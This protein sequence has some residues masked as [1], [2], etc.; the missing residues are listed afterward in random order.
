MKRGWVSLFASLIL[1][2]TVA[3]CTGN[4]NDNGSSDS[5]SKDDSL[6]ASNGKFT[7]EVTMTTARGVG[8]DVVFKNGDT[9]ENN[10]HTRW[11]KDTL[12]IDIKYLWTVADQNGA[13]DTK[14][15]LS[16]SANEPFPD[17]L[18]LRSDLVA[19]D[20]IDSGKFADG[21]ALFDKYA[22]DAWKAAMNEAPSAWYPYMR[23][24]KRI[25]IPILERAYNADT[26]LWIR[27]D[28]LKKL[29][30]KAPTTI[31]ELDAVMDAF[32]NQD[33]DGND[34]K[35]T[36]G[37]AVGF[38]D[39]FNGWGSTVDW[40]LGAY[41]ALP[42][43]WNEDKDGKLVYGSVQPEAKLG[44]TKLHD[45]MAKGYITKEAGIMDE[46]KPTESFVAGKTG[47]VAGPYWMV[48]WPIGAVKDNVPGA[49]IKAYPI[50]AGPNGTVMRHGTPG[51]N[52]VV[53]INKDMKHPEIFFA[54]Q[55]YLFDHYA[56]PAKGDPMEFGMHQGYDY[57]L[58]DNKPVY[59]ADIPGG[60]IEVEKY[61]LTFDGAIIPSLNMKTLA[62][63]G[64][65][66]APE[67][68]FEVKNS[69]GYAPEMLAAAGVV[70]QQ[71][72]ASHPDK[73]IGA[74]TPTMKA[75]GEFLNKLVLETYNKMIYG[76]IPI[77]H[78]EDFVTQWKQSGGDQMTAEAN[79]WYA[80][81]QGK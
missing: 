56:N 40:V 50:P 35:D 64:A 21:G 13:L 44:L 65:G 26:V 14:L 48:A 19:Q 39:R 6:P 12:G 76:D 34:K 60:A 3:G 59:G 79:D 57:D 28:W 18:P 15:R 33:P 52:G 25:G 24:G 11:A 51:N 20:L 62:A 45:W 63:L 67:S 7:P 78:F 31:D 17:V 38:K 69:H 68:P 36:Y 10:V 75:K 71:V 2:G 61:S 81:V 66:K 47:I 37:M 5:A 22:S 74:P 9:M 46:V 49:E 42:N 55:N 16:L 72:D 73:F 41:G 53:L 58:V 4:N 77:D 30:L 32:V 27:E 43:Q 23:D 54:Y 29:N 70:M 80:S 8:G 1:V